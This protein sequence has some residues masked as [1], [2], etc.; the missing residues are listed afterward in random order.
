MELGGLEKGRL[1]KDSLSKYED[2]SQRREKTKV[3]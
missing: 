1:S 3:A 2:E